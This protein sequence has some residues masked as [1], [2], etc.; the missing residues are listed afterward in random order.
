MP[1]KQSLQLKILHVNQRLRQ[2]KGQTKKQNKPLIKAIFYISLTY[3]S[4][5]KRTALRKIKKDGAEKLQVITHFGK[6]HATPY[7]AN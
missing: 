3:V 2:P 6:P 1:K 7:A 4:Y 5:T